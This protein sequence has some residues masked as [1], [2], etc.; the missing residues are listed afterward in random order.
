MASQLRSA[1]LGQTIVKAGGDCHW[2]TP[3][4][5]YT[6][7]N[8]YADVILE[9]AENWEYSHWLRATDFGFS[10]PTGA[11]INGIKVEI[12]KKSDAPYDIHD[13]SVKI[14]DE[15]Y[16]AGTE[17]KLLGDWTGTDTYYVYGGSTDLWGTSWSDSEINAESFGLYIS[18]Y[19]NHGIVIKD[20]YIDHITIKIYYA[21]GGP[22]DGPNESMINRLIN[23]N[24]NNRIN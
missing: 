12:E 17:H 13:E 24:L 6:S 4:N 2:S 20:A 23:T 9:G 3:T 14:V 19:N 16:E 22:S 21:E 5:I 18:A 7:N 10:I 1:R 8:A 15:G 11:I